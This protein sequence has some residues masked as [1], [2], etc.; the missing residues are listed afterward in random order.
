MHNELT[1]KDIQM[2]KEELDYRRLQELGPELDAAVVQLLLHHLNVFFGQFIVHGGIPLVLCC[3]TII[4]QSAGGM[5]ECAIFFGCPARGSA[6]AEFPLLLPPED[7]AQPPD[8]PGEH[9][10][11]QNQG[12]K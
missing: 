2:M 5:V 10:Q 1:K 8:V 9:D 3:S 11:G 6:A 4:T 7:A 12:Q